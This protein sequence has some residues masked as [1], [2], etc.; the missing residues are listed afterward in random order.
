MPRFAPEHFAYLH[1]TSSAE[2]KRFRAGLE[3]LLQ[4]GVVQTFTLRN[5]ASRVP[6]L[7]AVGPLQFEVLQYRLKSEYGAASQLEASPWAVVRWPDAACA[8]KVSEDELPTGARL[9][10][11]ADGHL[12]I[13]FAKDWD[14]KYYT[15]KHPELTLSKLPPGS[16]VAVS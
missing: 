2:F 7:G 5:A 3:H 14:C 12:V 4:E 10:E 15:D 8:P 11:D 9:A 1:S 16:S 13:L 6:L